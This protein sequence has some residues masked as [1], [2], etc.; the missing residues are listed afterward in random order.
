MY[1]VW[2]L[3]F[4]IYSLDDEKKRYTSLTMA[5]RLGL[6]DFFSLDVSI[7]ISI[8]CFIL[9]D[10]VDK[11]QCLRKNSTHTKSTFTIYGINMP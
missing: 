7:L 10:S 5:E 11:V 8:Y 1:V 4:L 9:Y 6:P 3:L 2:L